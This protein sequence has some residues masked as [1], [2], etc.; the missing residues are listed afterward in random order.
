[1]CILHIFTD[2]VMHQ[3][4]QSP[5]VVDGMLRH[6]LYHQGLCG[7]SG[8]QIVLQLELKMGVRHKVSLIC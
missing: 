8:K 7:Y 5:V 6:K 4:S 1:M 2:L 3:T